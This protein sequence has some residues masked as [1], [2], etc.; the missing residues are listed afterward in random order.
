MT[1]VAFT[2]NGCPLLTGSRRSEIAE[3]AQ[4][5]HR[6]GRVDKLLYFPHE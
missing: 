4:M 5:V 3:A 6:G 2:V 1:K